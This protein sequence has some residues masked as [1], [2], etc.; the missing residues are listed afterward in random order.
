MG[1]GRSGAVRRGHPGQRARVAATGN[2]G[3]ARVSHVHLAHISPVS[4][5]EMGRRYC[6]RACDGSFERAITSNT[7]SAQLLWCG[8]A[9]AIIDRG[10]DVGLHRRVHDSPGFEAFM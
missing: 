7:R 6:I 3:I 5:A 10:P 4:H 2:A 1:S 8:R 9:Y